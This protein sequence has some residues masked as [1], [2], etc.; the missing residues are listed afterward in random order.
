MSAVTGLISETD[1]SSELVKDERLKDAAFVLGANG[2]SGIVDTQGRLYIIKII[3]RQDEHPAPLQ[4]V[5]KFIE[6]VLKREKAV[7]EAEAAAKGFLDKVKAGGDFAGL[8][9][10][11][12]IRQARRNLS[13][14]PRALFRALTYLLRKTARYSTLPRRTLITECRLRR[15]RVPMSFV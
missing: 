12:A 2:I 5:K 4:A 13:P 6:D 9:K 3:E 10:K 11:K 15:A 7:E 1:A 8:A 14:W